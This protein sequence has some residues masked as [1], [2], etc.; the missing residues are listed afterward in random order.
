MYLFLFLSLMIFQNRYFKNNTK[1]TR[2]MLYFF[3]TLPSLHFMY[4]I[5]NFKSTQ[6]RNF[7]PLLTS[8]SCTS[9]ISTFLFIYSCGFIRFYNL[10]HRQIKIYIFEDAV[11]KSRNVSAD[12]TQDPETWSL[13]KMTTTVPT[14]NGFF[15]AKIK[16]DWN[17]WIWIQI[18]LSCHAYLCYLSYCKEK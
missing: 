2:K 13:N 10:K 15:I 18:N 16:W 5:F 8:L 3:Y 7:S 6:T 1:Y 12:L 14:K 9:S 4:T 11:N 17:I